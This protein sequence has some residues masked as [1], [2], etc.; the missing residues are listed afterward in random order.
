MTVSCISATKLDQIT[1]NSTSRSVSAFL[2]NFD[3]NSFLQYDFSVTDRTSIRFQHVHCSRLQPCSYDSESSIRQFTAAEERMQSRN[4]RTVSKMN[5]ADNNTNA[6]RITEAMS[7]TN[8]YM[9]TISD[10]F[11]AFSTAL[12]F[13]HA[14]RSGQHCSRVDTIRLLRYD[15][16]KD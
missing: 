10:S 14:H 11:S 7:N 3:S 4:S 15:S 12:R 2:W 1:Y 13:Q 6:T 5:T 8:R 16:L 9:H